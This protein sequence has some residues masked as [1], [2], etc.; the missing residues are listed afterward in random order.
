[1]T[2]MNE[3]ILSPNLSSKHFLS[4][5]ENEEIATLDL[6]NPVANI[7]IE[8]P[9]YHELQVIGKI[10][11]LFKIGWF[12]FEI[13][14]KKKLLVYCSHSQQIKTTSQDNNWN[15]LQIGTII[16][17]KYV[18]PYF[19]SHKLLGFVVTDHSELTIISN[20]ISDSN[21]YIQWNI[22]TLF[23][24]RCLTYTIWS[25]HFIE[26]L[27]RME[28]PPNK[29]QYLYQLLKQ[30]EQVMGF[31]H[32]PISSEHHS[33][34][35]SKPSSSSKKSTNIEL[36]LSKDNLFSYQHNDL[37]SIDLYFIRGGHSEEY[38]YQCLPHVTSPCLSHISSL[39]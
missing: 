10:N 39:F 13:N 3:T 14:N 21:K 4:N 9:Y 26:E 36:T 32:S 28:L 5:Q 17:L 23:R 18:I 31:G 6:T 22:F 1:M 35:Y 8:W 38:L 11:K 7:V 12:E 33:I 16:S 24:T 25:I 2:T 37:W 15:K 19:K 29:T 30:Y 27:L 20:P 34:A